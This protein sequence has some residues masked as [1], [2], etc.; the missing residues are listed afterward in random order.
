M[1]IAH[2]YAP[3]C[4]ILPSTLQ[5]RSGDV[6]GFRD[7]GEYRR[8]PARAPPCLTTPH[9]P[10]LRTFGS[11]MPPRISRRFARFVRSGDDRAR[12]GRNSGTPI[13]T[14]RPPEPSALNAI[15]KICIGHTG[16]STIRTGQNRPCRS[17]M[18]CS[19]RKCA[20]WE[21]RSTVRNH[22]RAVHWIN[23]T[24][25]QQNPRRRHRQQALL[26]ATTKSSIGLTAAYCMRLIAIDHHLRRTR[27]GVMMELMTKAIGSRRNLHD[28]Q[29]LQAAGSGVGPLPG[30]RPFSQAR[31]AIKCASTPSSRR[32]TDNFHPGL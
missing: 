30:S 31:P 6:G 8:V 22:C 12:N 23:L 11:I 25:T 27:T 14:V 3:N 4:Q 21:M 5:H 2:R 10:S 18:V 15:T 16:G 28:Q 24:I 32:A 29:V 7:K 1:R 17:A 13:A 26:Q 20:C 19:G 9:Q